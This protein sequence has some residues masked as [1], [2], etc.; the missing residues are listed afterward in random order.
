[1]IHDIGNWFLLHLKVNHAKSTYYPGRWF[2]EKQTVLSA[3]FHA[4]VFYSQVDSL[5]M[6]DWQYNSIIER[7]LKELIEKRSN[8]SEDYAYRIDMHMRKNTISA[9]Q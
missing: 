7:E 9:I 2:L 3:S 6:Q 1:M 8:K 4:E 5:A